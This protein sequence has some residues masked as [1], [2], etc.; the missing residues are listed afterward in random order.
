[1]DESIFKK[2]D[3]RGIYPDQINEEVIFKIACAFAIFVKQYSGIEKPKIVIGHDIRESSEALNESLKKGLQGCEVIDIGLCSTPLNFFANWHLK[4][5]ASVMITASHNP[6]EYNGLKLYL[7]DVTALAEI[8]GIAKVKKIALTTDFQEKGR[9]S[10]QEIDLSDEYIQYIAKDVGNFKIAVDCG[11]GMAGPFFKKL[12][13][14]I[15]LKYEGLYMEPDGSFPNHSPNPMDTETLKDLQE[16]MKKEKFDLGVAFDGDGDRLRVLDKNGNPVRPDSLIGIFAK[17]FLMKS[18]K[19]VFDT[20]VSRGVKEE[21]EERGGEVIKSAVGYPNIKRIMRKQ[22]IFFGG[23][24][25]GH[26]FWQD[27]CYSESPLL[28]LVRL[29]EIMENKSIE[30]LKKPFEG[31]FSP[32]EI[33]FKGSASKLKELERKYSDAQISYLDGL[34]VDAK[35]QELLDEKLEE[36]KSLI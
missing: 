1:M 25:S 9:G 18:K 2:Y 28:T 35:N 8:D 13:D 20:R 30:E 10:A 22:E 11:N 23:E 36:I 14:K 34:T 12:A 16:L 3:I 17:E 4:T 27:F 32:G 5:N 33:N 19:V 29:L 24:L 6:K 31:Y 21:I 26:F 15:N 7:R